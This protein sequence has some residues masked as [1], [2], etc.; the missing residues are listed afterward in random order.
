MLES[1]EHC[2]SLLTTSQPMLHNDKLCQ[3]DLNRT[4][5]RD[6]IV[7]FGMVSSF[8]YPTS[9]PPNHD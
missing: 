5:L 7:Q 4:G 3:V 9:N 2:I 6:Y 1:E 8:Q